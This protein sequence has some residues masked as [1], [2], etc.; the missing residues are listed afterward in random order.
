MSQA[1]SH[2]GEPSSTSGAAGAARHQPRSAPFDGSRV[3]SY[4][5]EVFTGFAAG[6]SRRSRDVWANAKRFA[7]RCITGG[8]TGTTPIR[9]MANAGEENAP[10]LEREANAK[11]SIK[12]SH[13]G[14]VKTLGAR[15]FVQRG[16][17]PSGRAAQ[18]ETE[19]V[20]RRET[21]SR[22]EANEA[23]VLEIEAVD[24]RSQSYA[25]RA[26]SLRS[27]KAAQA[28]QALVSGLHGKPR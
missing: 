18:A 4:S 2:G 27:R 19:R 14:V 10:A 20:R 8:A 28:N 15:S 7:S 5:G 13:H 9:L 1:S 6:R 24:G 3:G 17:T 25:S 23:R 16:A 26:R 21:R 22:R 12:R 11:A